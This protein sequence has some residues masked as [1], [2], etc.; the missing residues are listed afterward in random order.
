MNMM[1]KNILALALMIVLTMSAGA[2]Q[3]YQLSQYLQNLYVLNSAT[4]GLHDYTEV[5]LSYRNQ[6]VGITNSPT[7][8]YVSVNTPIGKRV[9]INPQS[10]SL[11]ISSPTAY[12]S[13]TRKSY[14]A[15]GGYVLQDAS[16]ASAQQIASLSYTFHLPITKELSV[17]FSPSVGYRNS[18]FFQD[19]AKTELPNDPTYNLYTAQ[20]PGAQMDVNIAAWLYHPKFFVGYSTAQLVQDRLKFN[21]LISYEEIKVHHNLIM[22]YNYKINRNLILTPSVLLRYVD[23][24]PFAFDVNFRLDYRDLFW[25]GLSYR[26]SNSLIAMIGMHLSNTLRFGY[27]FDLGLTPIRTRNAGSHE[28]MLGLNLSNKEKAI[29]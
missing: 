10:S 13:V 22:G 24:A 18:T 17:S 12:N 25:S 26:N 5:N 27:A 2:Q 15:I 1:I 6:W 11:R 16:G 3:I 8:Y 23:L 29:F 28:I 9:E 21:D 4:A 19:K 7:T 20:N 14:H